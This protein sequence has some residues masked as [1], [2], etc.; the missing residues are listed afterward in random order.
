MA[1]PGYGPNGERLDASGLTT[2]EANAP[3]LFV[4]DYFDIWHI[5]PLG[6]VALPYLDQDDD[7]VWG[8]IYPGGAPT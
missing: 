4:G 1:D 6:V 7:E 3:P 5:Q 8:S 2:W